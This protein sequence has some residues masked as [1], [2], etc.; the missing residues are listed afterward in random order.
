MAAVLGARKEAILEAKDPE[1]AMV[2]EYRAL[3]TTRALADAE[4]RIGKSMTMVLMGFP[5]GKS[6]VRELALILQAGLEAER[7][8]S[9][10]S[11]DPVSYDDAC[12]VLD[13]VGL[14][15]AAEAIGDA[16]AAVLQY[17]EKKEP[18]GEDLPEK[19]A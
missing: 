15:P 18:A 12:D 17:G 13:M 6:G 7:R 10:A 16:V 14:T 4:A 19:N 9:K 2:K 5:T 8:A 11:G 3:F 1:G